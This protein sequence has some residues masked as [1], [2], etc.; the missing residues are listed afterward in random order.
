MRLRWHAAKGRTLR[1]IAERLQRTEDAIVSKA[2]ELRIAI[3]PER[4]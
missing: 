1:Q 3:Q 2:S 4:P